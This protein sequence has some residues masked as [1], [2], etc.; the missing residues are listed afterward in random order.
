MEPV[1]KYLW[2]KEEAVSDMLETCQQHLDRLLEI[3]GSY[4]VIPSDMVCG[5][6]SSEPWGSNSPYLLSCS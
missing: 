2:T 5:A 1:H 4:E 6:T 3:I